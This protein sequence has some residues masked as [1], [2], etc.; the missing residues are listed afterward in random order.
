MDAERVALWRA[1]L[2][3]RV[4]ELGALSSASYVHFDEAMTWLAATHSELVRLCADLREEAESMVPPGL[5]NG[6]WI[7][8]FWVGYRR[9]NERCQEG[10]GARDR[11]RFH[12]DSV[13]M[14]LAV[15]QLFDRVAQEEGE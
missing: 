10:P 14:A 9:L 7:E 5:G 15:L 4:T 6:V 8:R 11:A 1:S 12:L 13:L 3:Q 2:E